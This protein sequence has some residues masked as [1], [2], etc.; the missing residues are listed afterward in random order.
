MAT[1]L[2]EPELIDRLRERG[3]RVTSQRLVLHRVLAELD[4]HV[5]AEE[6]LRAAEP[7]LPNLSLPTVYATLDLLEELGAVRRLVAPGGAALY[8]PRAEDHHHL[9]CRR[10]GA[11]VDVDGEFE[12]EPLLKAARAAGAEPEGLQV[13]LSG[14]CPAC[15]ANGR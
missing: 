9:A 12:A 11:V 4:R 6:V 10:C 5:A 7:R 13:V 2:S 8:D 15:A 14:L 3:Q 1:T